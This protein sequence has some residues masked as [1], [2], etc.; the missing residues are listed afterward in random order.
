LGGLSMGAMQSVAIGL[1]HPQLFHYVLA[2]SGGFGSLGIQTGSTE[3][4]ATS[5]W[6]EILAD[7]KET[8]KWL[9]VL[10]LSCG[11]QETGLL[12]PGR[13]LAKLLQDKGINAHWADYPGGHV[14]SVWRND[15]N[16]S[17]PLLFR[18]ASK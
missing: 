4:E 7:P 11:Q 16:V 1:T 17:A 13:R 10:F 6:R 15:L 3:S 8:S 5:P 12:E 9:H 14:F 18:P 2:Y